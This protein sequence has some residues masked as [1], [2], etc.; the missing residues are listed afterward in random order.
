[1][2]VQLADVRSWREFSG[3]EHDYPFPL[4]LGRIPHAHWAHWGPSTYVGGDLFRHETG[5]LH[6]L[7]ST[8]ALWSDWGLHLGGRQRIVFYCGSGWRSAVAWCIARLVGHEDCASYDG[9]MLEWSMLDEGAARHPIERGV[10]PSTALAAA[11]ACR[12]AAAG[13]APPS[14]VTRSPH[15]PAST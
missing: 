13:A 1:V 9:G 14:A 5:E 11:T 3:G 2:H 6:P 10:L 15:E 7:A 12:P 8:V 4:P